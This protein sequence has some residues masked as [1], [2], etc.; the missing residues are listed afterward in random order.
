[1]KKK[2]HVIIGLAASF[3]LVLPLAAQDVVVPVDLQ[4]ALF[5]KVLSYD[6]ALMSKDS[7]RIVFCIAYQ[8]RYLT[9][10]NIRDEFIR[11]IENSPVKSINGRN[12][13]CISVDLINEDIDKTFESNNIDVLYLAPVRAL[14]IGNIAMVCSVH[15]ILSITGVPEYCERGITVGIG[16]TG[17]KPQI[18]VNMKGALSV[19][20]DFSSQFLKLVKVL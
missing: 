9:S 19:G 5:C 3:I 1:M 20:A 2:L 4:Y 17:E 7:D 18:I 15:K 14:D 8:S 10:R 6:R 13:E 11:S 12:I 16:Q